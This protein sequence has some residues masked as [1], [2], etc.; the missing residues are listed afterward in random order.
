M[1]FSGNQL[2]FILEKKLCFVDIY[3]QLVTLGT[4]NWWFSLWKQ[5]PT[6]L[7]Y[8]KLLSRQKLL[9]T[10]WSLFY[11][12]GSGEMTCHLWKNT[13]CYESPIYPFFKHKIKFAWLS[14]CIQQ[15]SSITPL[16]RINMEFRF[17]EQNV[18]HRL[19]ILHKYAYCP[20]QEFHWRRWWVI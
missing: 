8:S 15:N 4:F 11:P 9:P 3:L 13:F 7:C 20:L 19:L 18:V 14:T 6:G 5:H 2:S 10:M 16:F 1:H 17:R 12:V